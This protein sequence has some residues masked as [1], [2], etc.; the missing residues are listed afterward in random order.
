MKHNKTIKIRVTKN[1]RKIAENIFKNRK[2][3]I[4][5]KRKKEKYP[6]ETKNLQNKK[7][8]KQSKK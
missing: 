7:T 6:K 5:R 2:I 8:A 3:I 1:K 4:K